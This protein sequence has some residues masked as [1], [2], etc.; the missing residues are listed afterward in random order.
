MNGK[1]V[2]HELQK[3]DIDADASS[4]SY[5]A[6]IVESSDDAIISK[7]LDGIVR[8]W[9]NAAEHIFGYSAGEMIGKPITIIVPPELVE[10]EQGIL[11]R[12]RR[13]D[14]LHHYETRRLRKDGKQIEIS[15]TVSPIYGADGSIIGA[16]KI[17]RD[18]QLRKEQERMLGEQ[19][20][21]LDLSSDAIVVRDKNEGIAY[22]NKGAQQMYGWRRHEVLGKNIHQLL[23][24]EFP[25]PLD[26]IMRF[27]SR[28]SRWTGEL[29]HRRRDGSEV[30][31]ISR[32]VI[33]RGLDGK[34]S[35]VLE[36]N[37]DI[38]ARLAA[39]R[40]L[41][42]VNDELEMRV[43]ERTGTLKEMVA[44]LEAF[45]YSLSHDMRA[46]LRAIQGFA[47][48]LLEEGAKRLLAED[49]ELLGK[50][51]SSALRLDRLIQDV[52]AL[53]RISAESMTLSRIEID[54]II[55]NLIAERP[56]FQ[57]PLA[58]IQIPG[59][60]PAVCGHE[61]LLTQC[62]TN[63]LQNAVKFVPAGVAPHIVIRSEPLPDHQVRLWFED[64][65]IGIRPEAQ[66][67]IFGIF[68]RDH[69]A[70]GFPG[71]GIGLAIAKKAAARMDGSVGVESEPNKGS[72]FWLQL[73]TPRE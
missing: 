5:L 30:H 37:T 54:P 39:E 42:E 3:P 23:R 60:L 33:D 34:V 12:I 53:S 48:V 70:R 16:S 63:F 21:L 10:E 11:A 69:T 25:E 71:T 43:I 4:A 15:L 44:E 57:P 27:L 45:S 24:T 55:R 61:A 9:N 50:I 26:Q 47:Q 73:H 19:A 38:T 51:T 52:L 13:G 36:T 58:E 32:W 8:S 35:A 68:E 41:R 40:R 29:V 28:E 66:R 59:P 7:D 6:A 14:R 1:G 31:V 22:W 20:R 64:N 65:G 18:I 2:T 67:R 56:E 46:P 49:K 17:A 72:R 62:V